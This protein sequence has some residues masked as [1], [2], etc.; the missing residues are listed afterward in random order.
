MLAGNTQEDIE[1]RKHERKLALRGVWKMG[2]SQRWLRRTCRRWKKSIE[3]SHEP[4]EQSNGVHSVLPKVPLGV[5][6]L[7]NR[8]G[9]N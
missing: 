1:H 3:E 7:H 8:E 5:T 2:S 9:R 4:R 6:A